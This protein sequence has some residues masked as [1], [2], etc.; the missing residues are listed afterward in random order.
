MKPLLTGLVSVALLFFCHCRY[1]RVS[2]K[3]RNNTP[4]SFERLT[5]R[6]GDTL[7][8]VKDLAAGQTTTHFWSNRTYGKGFIKAVTKKGDTLLHAPINRHGEKFYYQGK[9]LVTMK[10]GQNEWK[11]DTLLVSS[12][13]RIFF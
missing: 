3:I 7:H 6:F 11:H 10:L 13:R 4:Y 8:I 9:I 1:N 2:V 12:R 5:V